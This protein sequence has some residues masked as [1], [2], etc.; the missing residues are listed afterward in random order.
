MRYLTDRKRAVG[1][2]SA[3]RGTEH[4]WWMT[5]SSYALIPL[6]ILFLLT[7]GRALGSSYEDVLIYYSHPFPAIVAALTYVTALL[8][9]KNGARVAI[10]DYVGGYARKLWI[11]G[12]TCLSYA[13]MACGLTAIAGLA[14]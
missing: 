2:G 8:H 13:L 14:F 1:L 9:F 5:V 4:H 3:H 7:F 12:V 10:E 6:V 11:V